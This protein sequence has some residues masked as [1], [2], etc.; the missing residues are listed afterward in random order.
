MFLDLQ[1]TFAALDSGRCFKASSALLDVK[2]RA[3]VLQVKLLESKELTERASSEVSNLAEEARVLSL[4]IENALQVQR[5]AIAA[6]ESIKLE[7][8]ACISR[9]PGLL[10]RFYKQLENFFI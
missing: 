8:S 6:E 1:P 7:L 4:K 3:N 9:V 10:I 2:Q 5:E